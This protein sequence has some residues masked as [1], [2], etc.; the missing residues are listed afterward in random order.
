MFVFLFVSIFFLWIFFIVDM[1]HLR[2]F[3]ILHL[4]TSSMILYRDV[5]TIKIFAMWSRFCTN[6]PKRWSL[7]KLFVIYETCT[8][9]WATLKIKH[10]RFH[11]KCKPKMWKKKIWTANQPASNWTD[12]FWCNI[13]SSLNRNYDQSCNNN[14][15]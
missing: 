14:V 7:T 8:V 11:H 12:Q 6:L 10:Y 5:T 3:R 9:H 1:N 13:M 4:V 2:T 15:K